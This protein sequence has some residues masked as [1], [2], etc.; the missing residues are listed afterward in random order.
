MRRIIAILLTNSAFGLLPAQTPFNGPIEGFTFDGPT[1]S[2]RP[3]L[4]LLGSASLGQPI[5]SGVSYASVAPRL[6]YALTFAGDHCVLVGGMGTDAVTRFKI[7]AAFSVPE[8]VAWSGDGSTAVLFSQGGSWIQKLSGLP[9]AVRVE[10]RLSLA[11]LGGSL[12]A[13]AVDAH[14]EKV[15]IA[16]SGASGAVYQ[17]NAV[18]SFAPLISIASPAALAF[19]EDAS[20]L[21]ALDTATNQINE[22]HAADW[23]SRSWPVEGLSNPI[24][25]RPAHDASRR[26]VVYVV[27]QSDRSLVS[28]DASTHQVLASLSLNFA[29][30]ELD[31][32]GRTSFLVGSR[33]GID[34]TLWSFSSAPQPAVYF[35]PATPVAQREN[36]RR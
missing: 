1:R 3:V 25:L 30:D 21:Y 19:S 28:Y 7:P 14:G 29:P 15:V 23:S 8:G 36:R 6:N 22:L 20:T 16:I 5:Y 11:S 26:A 33:S 9:N 17:V 12:S 35:V 31:P 27:G 2:V 34:D 10:D 18:G 13:V 4:G 24:A 32:L